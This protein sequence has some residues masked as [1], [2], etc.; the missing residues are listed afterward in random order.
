[1]VVENTILRG[2]QVTIYERQLK[3]LLKIENHPLSN[4]ANFTSYIFHEFSHISWAG[5][6]F[7]NNKHLYLGPFQGQIACEVI[8]F[9]EGVC[10]LSY[11]TK[12]PIIVANVHEFP[13]HIA[14]DS[15]SNSELVIPLIKDEE[16]IGVLD[17][18]S[19]QFSRFNEID[20]ELFQKLVDILLE[21]V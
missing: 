12:K 19:Y 9:N 7:S 5:F 18:D 15:G 17:L 6:Y 4:Y 14:C 13:G 11:S 10:G 8:N 21:V 1:M 20:L 16:V 3:A 2:K